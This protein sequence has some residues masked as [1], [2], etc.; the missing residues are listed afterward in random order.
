M[1]LIQWNRTRAARE[2][3][4]HG[5]YLVSNYERLGKS[6]KGVGWRYGWFERWFLNH[7]LSLRDSPEIWIAAQ[8]NALKEQWAE[9]QATISRLNAELS[10]LVKLARITDRPP[11]ALLEKMHELEKEQAVALGR[12][13]TFEQRL[14]ALQAQAGTAVHERELIS[15]L[16]HATDQ[17]P[18]LRLRQLIQNWVRRIEVFPNG[19]GQKP[20]SDGPAQA[21]RCFSI[22]FTDE[23]ASWVCC[24]NRNPAASQTVIAPMSRLQ[25][26][27]IS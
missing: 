24:S 11:G 14:D 18:R 5:C 22:T 25:D 20:F 27:G 6:E 3:P 12:A 26:G 7:L 21:R 2:S 23:L 9:E 16:A 4:D 8:E 15:K 1:R 13:T 10:R 19:G 17:I